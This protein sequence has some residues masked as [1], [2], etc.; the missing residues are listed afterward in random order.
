MTTIAIDA[1]GASR[2]GGGR[3]AVLNVLREVLRLDASR[4]YLLL[5]DRPEAEF[6]SLPQ[7][8][9]WAA[10]S[11]DR[12]LARAWAQMVWPAALRRRR[13]DLIHHMKNLGAFCVPGVRVYT[14]FDLTMFL[15]PE[16]YSP[17]ENYF[18]RHFQPR[19]LRE[20][21]HVVAISHLTEA[22]LL[23]RYHL[24]PK[25]VSVIYP[26]FNLRFVPLVP[27]ET[28]PV[29][30]RYGLGDHYLLHVG[31]LSRK[32]NLLTL[33][34]SYEVLCAEGYAGA[35][36]LVGRQYETGRDDAFFAHL[37]ASPLRDRVV[38]TGV[39]P[40][41]DLHSLYAGADVMVFPSL[42]EGF[43]IAP[44]EAMACG[45]PVVCSAGGALPEVVGDGGTIVADSHDPHVLAAAVT[46]LV[47]DA[48]AHAEA[49]RR[50]L[51]R[52]ALFSTREAARQ[53]LALYERLLANRSR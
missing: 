11:A 44:L 32:K 24:D 40:D 28:R 17:V 2:A 10:P 30:E 53:T 35:L 19:L 39:V 21:D 15:H 3:S 34:Q 16:V 12:T 14:I 29:R 27:E 49:S 50:A 33:L 26:A 31:S 7:V 23:E 41:D 52:A 46:P 1:L 43:G 25:R 38:L 6:S 36:C 4:S 18:W 45:C 8:E 42:H 22:D 37:A 5:V 20:A 48:V 47:S 9:Q 13:I 51:A